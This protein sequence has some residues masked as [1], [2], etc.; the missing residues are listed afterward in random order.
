MIRLLVHGLGLL[1]ASFALR[2]AVA[3]ASSVAFP[4][5]VPSC[6]ENPDE[7]LFA[8][9]VGN[10]KFKNGA[11]GW[12]LNKATPEKGGF[13][14]S[15]S[16]RVRGIDPADEKQFSSA[17]LALE[18]VP[19]ERELTLIAHVRGSAAEQAFMINA[20]AYDTES[21]SASP[22]ESW[23]KSFRCGPE[24]WTRIAETYVVPPG[25]DRLNL[26][27]INR[28]SADLLISHVHLI[29][30]AAKKAKLKV[31]NGPGVL[32][33]TA[34]TAVRAPRRGVEGK[35]TFP[36]PLR[37]RDQVPLTFDLM[38]EPEEALLGFRWLQREDGINWLCEVDVRPS[39]TGATVRWES[40]VLVGADRS[41]SLPAA[42]E[43][44][45]PEETRRWLEKTACVQWGDPDIME[46]ARSLGEGTAGVQE[47]VE[48]VLAFT[49]TNEGDGA[50]FVTLDAKNALHAGGSCTSRANLAAALLRAGGIPARTSAHL[51]TWS[52]PLYEHWHVE[53]WHPGAGWT[54][55]EPT[56]G[57]VRPQPW[58]LVVINVANP[59]DEQRAFDPSIAHSNVML[60]VADL[61]VHKHSPELL[62][63]SVP[64][65]GAP[66]EATCVAK[67]G[68]D[69]D[70]LEPLFTSARDW[71]L[72]LASGCE[73]GEQPAAMAWVRT[74]AQAGSADALHEALEKALKAA[75]EG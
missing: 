7:S 20:F 69:L 56:L 73:D 25:Y 58:T 63:A 59:E 43:P 54:W 71:W 32:R 26:F 37:Y 50:R 5:L 33:A 68:E 19:T 29:A 21:A 39:H 75:S 60:G 55:I 18:E 36:V 48:R 66:N 11:Q 64:G 23:S 52:G 6:Q 1:A 72:H 62:P 31:L 28:F 22:A 65:R 67:L 70:D 8:N 13:G 34:Q 15:D 45:V 41:P 42:G 12:R 46:K 40:L 53:Y 44:V 10:P 30:G 27:F 74:A 61:A 14:D 38:V 2:C 3:E 24:Q 51:P 17:G 47:Y 35:V 4:V 9:L 49:S 16:V 57:K